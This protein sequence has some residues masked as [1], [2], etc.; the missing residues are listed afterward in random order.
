M[1]YPEL[2]EQ[3]NQQYTTL[4]RSSIERATDYALANLSN[5]ITLT[6]L[7][8]V[9]GLSQ[10]ALHNAFIKRFQMSPMQ[11]VKQQRLVLVRKSLLNSYA[12][13]TVTEIAT[14]F[15]F[16]NLGSFAV[17]YKKKFGESPSET[18]LHKK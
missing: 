18:L 8:K 1:M 3:M 17:E 15:G 6:D 7:E 2:L 13:K 9:S 4:S 14:S 10:R 11:W 16:F 5:R 12:Q